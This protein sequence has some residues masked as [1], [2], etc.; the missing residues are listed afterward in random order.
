MPARN[1]RTRSTKRKQTPQL[2]WLAHPLARFT[3]VVGLVAIVLALGFCVLV[4]FHYDRLAARYDITTVGRIPMESRVLDGGGNLIGYLHGE[5]VGTPVPLDQ[6]SPYFLNALVAREDARF[7]RH[8]GLDHLGLA[9]A[10]LRDLKEQRTV[11]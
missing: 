6:I 4:L 3:I 5:N 8:N 10:R 11:Q 7:Y 2:S 1:K 9:R